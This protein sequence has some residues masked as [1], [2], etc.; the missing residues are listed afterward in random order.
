MIDKRDL[1]EAL[2]FIR[3]H[4]LVHCSP[5]T[6]A[7]KCGKCPALVWSECH[8]LGEVAVRLRSRIDEVEEGV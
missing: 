8:E 5:Y 1:V 2:D 6:G 3:S 7:T 4:F